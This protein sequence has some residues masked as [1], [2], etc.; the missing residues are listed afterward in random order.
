MLAIWKKINRVL[1]LA[2]VTCTSIASTIWF[3]NSTGPPITMSLLGTSDFA[4]EN[5]SRVHIHG[6]T[7]NYFKSTSHKLNP[8]G[9]SITMKQ[10]LSKFLPQIVLKPVSEHSNTWGVCPQTPL[11]VLIKCN[12]KCC[13]PTF[14]DLPTPLMML[15]LQHRS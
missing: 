15:R 5:Y 1:K 11:E 10:L 14:H 13:P 8:I 3:S 6:T 2:L 12:P 9:L 4:Y 7:S